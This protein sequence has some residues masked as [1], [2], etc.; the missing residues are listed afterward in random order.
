VCPEY[1]VTLVEVAHEECQPLEHQCLEDCS[2]LCTELGTDHYEY[3]MC[4]ANEW[5]DFKFEVKE[6]H[7]LHALNMEV[8]ASLEGNPQKEAERVHLEWK[9][10]DGQAWKP[11][12]Q[13][14]SHSAVVACR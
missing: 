13:L 8:R 4:E 12:R 1:E 10:D 11:D 5:K 6:E 14:V 9:M 2:V 7:L 3:Q